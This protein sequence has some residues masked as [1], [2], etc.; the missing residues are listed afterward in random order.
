MGG[1]Y[2]TGAYFGVGVSSVYFTR[3]R[4]FLVLC[5]VAVW[6]CIDDFQHHEPF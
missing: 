6:G 2:F 4:A 1:V 5:F 3:F